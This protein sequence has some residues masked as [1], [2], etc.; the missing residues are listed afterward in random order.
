MP[1]QLTTRIDELH[2]RRE[3]RWVLLDA[4]AQVLGRLASK[5]ANLLRG[6][7]KRFFT[8]DVDCGDFVV[9]TNAEKIRVTGSKAGQKT[10]FRHSGYA[11]GAK[12]VPFRLQMER[13]P[14]KVLLLAVKRMLPVNRLRAHQLKR[15]K[16]YVGSTHP[17]AAQI[18]PPRVEEV[19]NA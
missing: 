5:A 17:H 4:D 19:K 8:P 10:Y 7:H 9:V 18:L 16:V 13:D 14:R 3:R 6:K 2:A 15:L 12:V 11:A 1:T